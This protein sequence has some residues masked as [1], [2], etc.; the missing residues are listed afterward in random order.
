LVSLAKEFGVGVYDTDKFWIKNTNPK[1]INNTVFV[2]YT[3]LTDEDIVKGIHLLYKA[4]FNP[5]S[6]SGKT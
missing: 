6:L 4:W 3:S 1:K 5:E 2:S